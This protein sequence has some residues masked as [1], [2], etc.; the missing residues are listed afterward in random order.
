MENHNASPDPNAN[1]NVSGAA[2]DGRPLPSRAPTAA[3][4]AVA[5][6]T[7]IAKPGPS[8]TPR[9]G[10]TSIAYDRTAAPTIAAAT[11]SDSNGSPTHLSGGAPSARGN[12]ASGGPS[13]YGSPIPH[14]Y[15]R[16]LIHLAASV[17]ALLLSLAALA[18]G[19]LVSRGLARF[20]G[21]LD[22]LDGFV[23][24]LMAGLVVFGFA[25][26]AVE[27]AGGW[28]LVAVG[29]GFLGLALVERL[30]HVSHEA[31]HRIV[32]P[33]TVLAFGLHE[34]VDGVAL[35]GWQVDHHHGHQPTLPL[36][37]VLHRLPLGLAIWTLLRPHGVRV[38]AGALAAVGVATVIGYTL[39][40]RLLGALDGQASG[41]FQGLLAG[42]FL[43]AVL[44]QAGDAGSHGAHHHHHHHDD[45][46]GRHPHE[47]AHPHDH[48]HA[49]GHHAPGGW[50]AKLPAGA[51][52]LAALAL[53]IALGELRLPEAVADGALDG[54]L[55]ALRLALVAAPWLI[56]ALLAA[57]IVAA[58]APAGRDRPEPTRGPRRWISAAR[59]ALLGG[60]AP[61]CPCGPLPTYRAHLEQGAG[62]AAVA[63]LVAAP[64]LGLDA[65]L[66]TGAI[67]G[68][69]FTAVRAGL[70]VVVAVVLGITLGV[71]RPPGKLPRAR[72]QP[73]HDLGARVRLGV[74]TAIEEIVDHVVP[75]L[76]VGIALAAVL[77]PLASETPLATIA[78]WP[79]AAQAALIAVLGAALGLPAVAAA[80]IVAVLVRHGIAPGAGLALLLASPAASPAV[81]AVVARTA[82]RARAAALG[83]AV[84]AAAIA[85]G[86]VLGT[87]STPHDPL[88]AQTPGTG[89]WV[90]LAGVATLLALAL[91]RQ[92]PRGLV[93]QLFR[94]AGES[95]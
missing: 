9:D 13:R 12:G 66:V 77:E 82:G 34:L 90:A 76:L 49:H 87:A 27:H 19:P 52:A 40:N 17:L 18:A 32:L 6:I 5:R 79:P 35:A 7:V 39:G 31:A 50:F 11:P 2:H 69:G 46:G 41:L 83:L 58:A 20:P 4:S 68:G 3:T 80:P 36:A 67:L 88:G 70:A 8:S 85:L 48:A 1:A 60:P 78:A 61:L 91:V 94:P 25:P 15:A 53:L 30:G 26:E 65:L 24:V 54:G 62:A 64:A 29:G 28:G 10:Q 89:S 16:F 56:V 38:A 21:A 59:G 55:V 92:G 51:G 74:H 37:V 75:W 73:P 42:A 71:S 95:A 44:H 22:L 45:D 93:G 72:S 81:L 14:L 63:A 86:A 43:H 84:L 47:H 57:G 33:V 23:L